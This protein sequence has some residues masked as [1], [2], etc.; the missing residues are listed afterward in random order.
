MRWILAASK[1]VLL[2]VF[3]GLL[4][5]DSRAQNAP[6]D[7]GT[8]KGRIVWEGGDIAAPKVLDAVK[9]SQDKEHCLMKGPLY[10]EEWVIDKKTKGI[11]WTFVWLAPAPVISPTSAAPPREKMPI[12]PNLVQLA[13]DNVEIDQPCC[14]FVPHA[15]GVRVGQTLV[16]KNSS[17]IVHNVNYA[18]N[19]NTNPGKNVLVPAGQSYQIKGLKVDD[20]IPV[21]I[22]CD[23]HRWMN[24]WVRVFD[25]PY[26]AVTDEQGN[27]EMKLAPA[28]EYYLI[29]WHES[30]GWRDLEEKN[31]NGKDARV[32]G[33]KITIKG[34][35]KG[36]TVNDLGDLGLKP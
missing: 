5:A 16:A 6:T 12:H 18:G 28:G 29:V 32:I 14:V 33:K 13:Q 24:A 1:M 20:R 9:D 27:F 11:R 19:P 15:L 21:K 36:D 25:H 22:T 31:V 35:A 23:I 2:V 7:W 30:K 34:N 8:V 4:S 17:P 26:F 3:L 10:S